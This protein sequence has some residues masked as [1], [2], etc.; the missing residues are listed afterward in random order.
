MTPWW[1][2]LISVFLGGALGGVFSLWGV[3]IVQDRTDKREK[4]KLESEN[5]RDL[6]KLE[7]DKPSRLRP[8]RIAML[9]E[10]GEMLHDFDIPLEVMSDRSD[11]EDGVWLAVA[12]DAGGFIE[13]HRKLDIRVRLLFQHDESLVEA[14]NT[15]GVRLAK[16]DTTVEHGHHWVEPAWTKDL[17][18][19][20]RAH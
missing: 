15:W 8:D 6:R 11:G 9:Y 12:A 1:A 10:I 16:L 7:R 18:A 17:A 2:N 3:K 13:R 14:W 4:E 5:L 20:E 19:N